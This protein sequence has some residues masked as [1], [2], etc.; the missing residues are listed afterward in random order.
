MRT[1]Y[2]EMNRTIW[3][4]LALIFSILACTAPLP[5]EAP[6]LAGTVTYEAGEKVVPED[7]KGTIQAYAWEVLGLDIP[8]L[9]AGGKSGQVN[10][11]VST[12]DGVDVAIDL[13]GTTYVGLW[14][15]GA[16]SLS[17]GD[18]EVSG[19][20]YADVQDGSLG[21]FAVRVNQAMPTEAASALGLILSTYPGLQGYEFFE[22]PVEE[23][24]FQ[25]AASQADDIHLQ[26]WGVTLTGTTITAGVNPGALAGRSVAWVV[27]GSG[28]LAAPF[29]P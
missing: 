19:D 24:G 3:A 16:A 25:F 14:G 27:V 11:P 26:G 10:L 22:A 20:L 17:F 2:L 15:Q 6:R 4:G 13:A 18:S 8:D 7:A 12:M 28:S 1:G 5:E 21:A 9:I 29:Q 23:V